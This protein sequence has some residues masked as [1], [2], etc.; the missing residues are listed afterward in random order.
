MDVVLLDS[1]FVE[2]L[3][4]TDHEAIARRAE[5]VLR[6]VIADY[7]DDAKALAAARFLEAALKS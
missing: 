7:G 1:A 4:K 5:E 2:R 3:R 6:Q